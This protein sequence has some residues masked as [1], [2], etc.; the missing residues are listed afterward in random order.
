MPSRLA[1]S[2]IRP[3]HLAR[4]AWIYVRQSSLAQ[5]RTH[6]ASAARQYDLVQ[7]ALA[8]GWPREH[9]RVV[10]QDQGH[11][12]ASAAG[13]DGFQ[14][15]VAEVGLGRAGAV[16]SLEVSRLARSCSDWYRLLELCALADTLV[17]DEDGVYDPGQYND[18][19]LLGVKGTLSEAELHWLHSRLLGGKLEKAQ[20]GQ[21]RVRLPTGLVY[22]AA[23]QVVLDP[24]EEVRSA[25]R[26]VFALFEQ[27]GSALAVVQQAA[28][29][30]LRCPT[31]CWGGARDG[32]LVWGSWRHGRVLALLHNPAYAG[33][34]VYGRSTTRTRPLPGEPLRVKGCTRRV[35]PEDW[36]IV[37]RDAHPGYITEEQF[38]RNQQQLDDN[39]TVR[40]EDRRGAVRAGAAL[41]QGIVLCGRCGRRMTVRYLADGATPCYVCCQL[42]KQAAGPTCQTLRGDDL[43]AAVA[44]S[45]LDAMQPAQLAVSL[46][47]LEELEAR[48]RQID[49]QWQLRLERARYEADLAQRRY[50]R[51]DPD[52]RLVARSLERAWNDALAAVERLER[53]YAA[54]P[55]LAGGPVSA[56]ERRRILALARDL[57][58]VWRAP[59]TS[60]AERKQLLRLLVKDVALTRQASAVAVGIRW[61]T[62]A[63]TTLAVPLRRKCPDVRRTDPAVVARVCA[64]AGDHTDRQIAA[65]L[66][67]KGYRSG[68][69]G[70]LTPSKVGWIRFRYGIAT[71]CPES[72]AACASGLRRDGR[73]S[74]KA[75]AALLN[76]DV[77]T[78][79][80][81]C[82]DGRLEAVRARPHG[83]RWIAL[84]PARIAALRK[85]LKRRWSAGA[86]T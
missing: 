33:L 49:R 60:Q 34:Y 74:A 32:E 81:W 1:A 48:A 7:R 4:D 18:R 21:L 61:R 24:D 71:G 59:T 46:A 52:N 25:I 2:K 80:A 10:D 45:F 57:P 13:R 83:P 75:A 85:P 86:R 63:V 82:R 53:E 68:T 42:H 20:H 77:S 44:A 54:R 55:P 11:S 43:D 17:V 3:D 36:P 51:I 8:L 31:R 12:G 28:R 65:A 72:P 50:A 84:D 14:A 70:A 29:H 76:V 6:T 66:D 79:A 40:G 15:L 62:D 69:G 9:I 38:R 27:H 73:Y 35:A 58:A 37:L 23:G 67:H 26:L 64:L 30:A 41:L 78:I 22:D 19:L 16:L 56:A 5:V 39:R 47:A